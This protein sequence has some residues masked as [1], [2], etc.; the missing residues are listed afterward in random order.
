M[1]SHDHYK[2]D[3]KKV[4]KNDKICQLGKK[5]NSLKISIAFKYMIY[6]LQFKNISTDNYFCDD[7]KLLQRK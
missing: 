7:L 6:E 1:K 4:K 3:K 2:H 5:W